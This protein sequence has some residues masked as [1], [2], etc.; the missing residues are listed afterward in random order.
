MTERSHPCVGW[1]EDL[2]ALIDGELEPARRAAVEAHAA[3]CARCTAQ[4]EALRAVDARLAGIPLPEV[5]GRLSP[6]RI[7]GEPPAAASVEG[8]SPVRSTRGEAL[9]PRTAPPR[10]ERRRAAWKTGAPVRIA[11]AAGIVLALFWLL[12]PGRP[13]TPPPGGDPSPIA[14]APE[15]LDA[16]TD[17]EL[18]LAMDLE[19][20]ED[21]EVIANLELLE[22]LVALEG[23]RG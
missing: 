17:E 11:T 23:G 3:S 13:N 21:F 22:R 19:T 16:A 7:S 1:D 12:Q 9:R 6:P 8:P 20:V 4:L 15:T 2:S 18:A 14:E 5:E 10:S